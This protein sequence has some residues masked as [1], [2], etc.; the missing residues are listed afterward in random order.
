MQSYITYRVFG[1]YCLI[2]QGAIRVAHDLVVVCHH[3]I[4]DNIQKR[5]RTLRVN[6]IFMT[7]YPYIECIGARNFR[8]WADPYFIDSV[9]LKCAV[10]A[11]LQMTTRKYLR[12]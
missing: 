4:S 10:I 11:L 6:H 1:K 12:P 3:D 5:L 8:F 2:Q 7:Q 9:N